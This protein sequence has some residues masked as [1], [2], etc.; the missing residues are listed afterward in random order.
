MHV[1]MHARLHVC[2]QLAPC[3][4]CRPRCG[5]SHSH[6]HSVLTH[7]HCFVGY[8]CT[9]V[10]TGI[11]LSMRSAACVN[12]HPSAAPCACMHTYTSLLCVH[13]CVP[14]C[15]STQVYA[16]TCSHL[17]LCA[18][19]CAPLHNVYMRRYVPI[20]MGADMYMHACAPPPR[21]TSAHARSADFPRAVPL[22]RGLRGRARVT[23][24]R[25]GSAPFLPSPR[26][27]GRR[28][29]MTSRHGRP[30]PPRVEA[31]SRPRRPRR[32]RCRRRPPPRSRPAP[33]R[34]PPPLPA[35]PRPAQV[36]G[37]R[38]A[39]LCGCRLRPSA[40][41]RRERG[42]RAGVAAEEAGVG[43]GGGKRPLRG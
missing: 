41:K 12:A 25:A 5:Y 23:P 32:S 6:T 42:G 36:S 34:P 16:C 31:P 29:R 40:G 15:V 33:P 22:R 26:L 43:G 35:R 21:R 3:D 13:A 24:G 2:T 11:S 4:T 28:A 9:S 8:T 30:A 39:A 38:P 20:H 7:V 19:A 17:Q 37:S 27:N 18:C 1:N 14:T 10:H